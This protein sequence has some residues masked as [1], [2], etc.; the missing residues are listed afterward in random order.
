MK[1]STATTEFTPT[2]WENYEQVK[3]L[4]SGKGVSLANIQD[5]NL[6]AVRFS[7]LD[8]RNLM[9]FKVASAVKGT[10]E[11]YANR[12]IGK[13]VGMICERR[14]VLAKLYLETLDK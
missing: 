2:V 12:S 5:S 10:P 8:I 1:A 11:Y 4:V 13:A 3:P 6:R 9:Q 7:N 14:E